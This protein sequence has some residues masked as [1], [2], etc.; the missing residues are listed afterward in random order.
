MYIHDS[1]IHSEFSFDVPKDGSCSMDMVAKAAI[2]KGVS[3]ISICDH[4]D[5]DDI[6]DG[7]YP[8][9][10]AKAIKNEVLR[11]KE[12]YKGKLQI[13]YGIEL[14]QPH[15]RIE[16]AKALI[17]DCGFEFVI[18]S[19]HNLRA[20]PDFCFMS[21]KLMP[22]SMIDYIARR[23]LSELSELIDFGNFTTL[24]HITYMKRYLINDGVEFDYKPYYD[25]L[26]KIFKKL[27]AK[28]I[29]LEVNTSGLRRGSTTLPEPE[30]CALYHEVGGELITLGSDAHLPKDIA[31][32]F[33]ESVS[34]L[35][36]IGFKSQTVIRGGK[37]TQIEL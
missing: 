35:K 17:E 32:G 29:S 16:E 8:A 27:I 1:H 34:F 13:N 10:D 31:S 2:S 3:E 21:Y 12:K 22:E 14:G 7:L 36:D 9:Y 11:V 24:A 33:E 23:N 15:T 4:C 20:Y 30:I 6:L 18:G 25:E 5:I 26:E 37:P 19:I 28:G